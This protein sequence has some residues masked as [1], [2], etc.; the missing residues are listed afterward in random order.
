M[1]LWRNHEGEEREYIPLAEL[2]RIPAQTAKQVMIQ[3]I[4]EAERDAL[5]S[6]PDKLHEILR[7]P[8]LRNDRVF[9]QHRVR[10]L[11]IAARLSA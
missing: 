11:R 1:R 5:P 3:K 4:R 7:M 6:R 10:E 8:V 9:R 2:G